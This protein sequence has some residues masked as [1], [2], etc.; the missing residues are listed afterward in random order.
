MP[1]KTCIIT[2]ASRGIG[3]A[4]ALR[5]A[6]SG[7]NLVIAASH[8]NELQR[9]AGQV[10]AAGAECAAVVGDIRLPE[11]AGRLIET[12]TQRFGRIDVLINNAGFGVLKPVDQTTPEDFDRTLAVNVGAV[13]YMTRAVWPVMRKQGGGIIV[14][15][16]SAASTDPFRGLSVYGATKA[17][18]NLFTQATADEGRALGIRVYAIAPGAVE[19]TM[20]RGMLPDLP[21]EHVLDPDA[22]AAAIEAMCGEGLAHSSGQTVFVRKQ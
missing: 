10:A 3:L 8:E 20:L 16:S 21:A 19:T 18:V 14:N 9:A 15:V 11:S 6:R 13:F 4:T 7:Y 17:W 12:A 22:V 5:F 1:A 2:G